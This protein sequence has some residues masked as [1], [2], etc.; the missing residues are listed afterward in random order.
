MNEERLTDQLQDAL[1]QRLYKM[2]EARF[3]NESHT[4][5][6]VQ[7]VEAGAVLVSE[8]DTPDAWRQMLA[9]LSTVDPFPAITNQELAERVKAEAREVRARLF[10]VL[11]G[12]QVSAL[13]LGDLA[14]AQGIEASKQSLRDITA[15]DLSAATTAE[16]MRLAFRQAYAGI[17]SAA[18]VTVRAAFRD[19]VK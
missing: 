8:R 1:P 10:S 12:M 2:M 19:W 17:A 4:A 6:I 7:T 16:E 9:D 11:D 14:G 15:I 13:T 3:A 5:A 18:P